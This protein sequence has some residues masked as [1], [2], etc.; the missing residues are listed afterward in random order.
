MYWFRPRL[1]GLHIQLLVT[2]I[3]KSVLSRQSN[4]TRRAG[5]DG[6]QSRRSDR[7]DLGVS[8]LR[9]HTGEAMRPCSVGRFGRLPV[10]R[11]TT[12]A[13]HFGCSF[14]AVAI[15]PYSFLPVFFSLPSEFLIG[16]SAAA[17]IALVTSVANLGGFVG[18]YTVGLIRQRTGSSYYGLICAGV[19]SFL[20]QRAWPCFSPSVLPL[21]RIHN[22]QTPA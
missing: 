13:I 6:S 8:P 19:F 11:R 20:F 22:P 17:G 21:A 3:M 15:R 10:T 2:Q 4:T 18:P 1:C 12:L 16:F 5:C 7:N 14:S 9:A